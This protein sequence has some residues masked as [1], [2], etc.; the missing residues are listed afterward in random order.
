M[1]DINLFTFAGR[2]LAVET[3]EFASGELARLTI[4]TDETVSFNGEKGKVQRTKHTVTGFGDV[5]QT[6]KALQQGDYVI[7]QGKGR[8]R[9]GETKDGR[10]FTSYDL[11]VN[12]ISPPFVLKSAQPAAAAPVQEAQNQ[13][14][15]QP[16]QTQAHETGGF[17][18]DIPF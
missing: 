14:H 13:Q 7:V 18:D 10:R 16:A 4:V 17:D 9:D 11:V 15:R 12:R 2:A 3:K 8:S 5:A 1:Q 6:M